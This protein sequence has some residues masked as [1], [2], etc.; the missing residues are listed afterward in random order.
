MCGI[1]G[2]INLQNIE[3][4]SPLNLNLEIKFIDSKLS[5]RGDE[6]YSIKYLPNNNFFYH[7]RLSIIDL[8]IR[9]KQLMSAS[10]SNIM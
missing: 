1:A 7:N 4:S 5:H 6:K 8:N 9:S 3:K 2:L 10:L